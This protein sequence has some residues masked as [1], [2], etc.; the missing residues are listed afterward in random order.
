MKNENIFISIITVTYNA[1]KTIERTIRSVINQ[2]IYNYEYLI[3][4]GGS[5]DNTIDIVKRY[6][7]K[8]AVFISEKD[9]GIYFA[10]N[11]GAENAKGDYLYFLNSDDYFVD[12]NILN[13]IQL[14]LVSYS[15][16]PDVVYG[17]IYSLT[18][19]N[20]ILQCPVPPNIDRISQFINL[21]IHHPGS[22]IKHTVFNELGGFN[23]QYMYSSDYD[24]FLRCFLRGYSFRKIDLYFS[25]MSEGGAGTK[26]LFVAIKEFE[27]S[28]RTNNAPFYIRCFAILRGISIILMKKSKILVYLH[29]LS[30]IHRFGKKQ[31]GASSIRM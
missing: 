12:L 23:I 24:L 22:M 29:K 9:N 18:K 20:E 15:K 5:T 25:C 8:I 16:K 2:N 17:N 7:D 3:I 10:M 4:D 27:L 14:S 1:E 13:R 28:L 30:R 6:L 26:N 11:K 31:D 21:P 19:S